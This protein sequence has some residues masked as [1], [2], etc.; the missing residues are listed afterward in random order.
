MEA[1]CACR[2][3]SVGPFLRNVKLLSFL[4][5]WSY[6][7]EWVFSFLAWRIYF[8]IPVFLERSEEK[9]G[10]LNTPCGTFIS[11]SY[12]MSI[13]PSAFGCFCCSQ[14]QKRPLQITNLRCRGW[15]AAVAGRSEVREDSWGAVPV[16]T[17]TCSEYFSF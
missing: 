11:S 7:P 16:L 8:F 4:W 2:V 10:S 5:G 9:V 14:V 1:L 12:S 3:I 15:A 17:Q 6:F 13:S